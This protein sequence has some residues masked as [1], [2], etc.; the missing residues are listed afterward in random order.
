MMEYIVAGL[1][2]AILLWLVSTWFYEGHHRRCTVITRCPKC[3]AEG[4]TRCA[5]GD[6]K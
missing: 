5:S 3:G 1:D 2:L 4:T 6:C